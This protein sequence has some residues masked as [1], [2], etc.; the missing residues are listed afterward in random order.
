MKVQLSILNNRIVKISLSIVFLIVCIVFFAPKALQFY[1]SPPNDF[2]TSNIPSAPNYELSEYWAATPSKIGTAS[3]LPEGVQNTNNSPMVDV[4]YIYPTTY[5]GPGEWNAALQENQF[6][7][8]GVNKVMIAQAGVFN[9]CCRIYAP[10]YRQAHINA[11]VPRDNEAGFKALDLA[12]SD[13]EH[14]FK[15]FLENFS[16][17]R[18]FII[19]SHS[20]GTAHAQRLLSTL[21]DKSELRKRLVAA[22][23][24]GYWLPTDVLTRNFDNIQLCTEFD[25][26]GCLVT[27]DTFDE[28]SEGLLPDTGVPQWYAEGWEWSNNKNTLCINPLSWQENSTKANRELNRGAIITPSAAGLLDFIFNRSPSYA[29]VSVPPLAIKHTAATCN[30]AGSLLVESQIDNVFAKPAFGDAM[31]YHEF[32]WNFFYM[33]I[34]ENVSQRIASY[35]ELFKS[36]ME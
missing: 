28:K 3:L 14:A 22:Y 16:Q 13:I 32:D 7:T 9:D 6:A 35:F 29:G 18:P 24:I 5:F 36:Q 23:I 10:H 34:R 27:F 31:S 12:Y 11:F 19:A 25:M 15:F 20:Q 17:G 33:N 1:F 8:Y 26:V 21:V 2:I 30:E 4:F